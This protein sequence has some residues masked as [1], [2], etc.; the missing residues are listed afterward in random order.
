MVRVYD[1]QGRPLIKKQQ[2]QHQGQ[3]TGGLVGKSQEQQQLG[4]QGQHQQQQQG[5]IAGDVD[6]PSQLHQQLERHQQHQQQQ[7]ETEETKEMGLS[8]IMGIRMSGAAVGQG[9]AGLPA[10]A[11]A[12]GGEGGGAAAAGGGGSGDG[13]G[14][15]TQYNSLVFQVLSPSGFK[16]VKQR[17]LPAMGSPAGGTTAAAAAAA[18]TKAAAGRGRDAEHR[19]GTGQMQGSAGSSGSANNSSSG[20]R[21]TSSNSNSNSNTSDRGIS[22]SSSSSSSGRGDASSRSGWSRSNKLEQ[23]ERDLTRHLLQVHPEPCRGFPVK[24]LM[25]QV[26]DGVRLQHSLVKGAGWKVVLVPYYDAELGDGGDVGRQTA[27]V[28][29]LLEK[30]TCV[31]M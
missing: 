30:H 12:A 17:A 15:Y 5:G 28:L 6:G 8:S 10:A 29:E 1:E 26:K 16:A 14:S 20:T 2:M 23:A 21:G 4:Q 24:K 3:E 11:A 7:E 19:A 31:G 25:Q 9:A 27:Y 18:G 13:G 22:S